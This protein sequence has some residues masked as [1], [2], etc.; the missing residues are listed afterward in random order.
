MANKS[1]KGK[2]DKDIKETKKTAKT[3]QNKPKTSNNKGHDNLIPV[4]KRTTEEQ[5]AIQV[6]GASNQDKQ[7]NAKRNSE[8]RLKRCYHC[9]QHKGIKKQSLRL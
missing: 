8:K 9:H 7:E 2:N 5:R 4:T 3:S 6:A 1:Q